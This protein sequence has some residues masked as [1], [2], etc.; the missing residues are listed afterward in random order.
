MRKFVWHRCNLAAKESGLKWTCVNN[1]DFTVL[2]SG[3]SRSLGVSMCTVWPFHSKWLSELEQWICIKIC[4]KLEHSSMATIW[5]NQKATAMGNWWLTA[6]SQQRV[7]LWNIKSPRWLSPAADQFWYPATFG[8]S[9]NQNHLWKGRDV[10]PLVRFR[11]IWW[12]RW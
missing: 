10:R 11:K 8:F 6:L 1:D 12:G 9:Q 5:M 7:F 2:V 4:I 3:G